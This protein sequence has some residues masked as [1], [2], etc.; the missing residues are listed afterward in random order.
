MNKFAFLI[1]PRDTTD[2]SRRFWFTRFLP[3]L[4]VDF[5]I[6]KL[7][8]R[9]GFTVCSKRI[10]F[11]RNNKKAEGC[12]IAILLT[13]RQMMS[14]PKDKVRQRILDAALYAQ[15]KLNVDVIGLGSLSASVTDGG[16]WLARQSG[17]NV[18][19]TH[20]DTFT[21]AVAQ[22]GIEKIIEKY[23]FSPEKNKIAIIGAYGIIGREICSFLARKG[24]Y[25]FLVE[26]IP[27]KVALIKKKMANEGLFDKILSLSTDLNN[28]CNA[29]LIVTATSHPTYLIEEKNLKKN[30]VVYDIA[31]P[32]NL[33]SR[34]IKNRPDVFRIDGGY[35]DIGA[36]DLKFPMGPPAGTTF[37]CL[38]ETA[39]IAMEEN[40]ENHIGSIDSSFIEKVKDWGD[41]YRLYHAR[42]TCFG[43]DINLNP[44]DGET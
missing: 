17:I 20:G 25:L 11:S 21:V 33:S 42:F 31:Q 43:R 12:I 18:A 14:L 10:Y 6:A 8:G 24:Y 37:A 23:N 13:G 38:T 1:H 27:E 19:V 7:S 39:M 35:V 2:V 44:K 15:N 28:V 26:S 3:S 34:V 40:F 32:I 9:L 5:V 29:D 22:Q 36:I 41:K 16:C 30:V 4:W